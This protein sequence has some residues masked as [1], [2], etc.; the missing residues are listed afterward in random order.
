MLDDAV[1]TIPQA[2]I[3]LVLTRSSLASSSSLTPAGA[4]SG[5]LHGRVPAMASV[6][7]DVDQIFFDYNPI[8]S[9]DT[10][11]GIYLHL[12]PHCAGCVSYCCIVNSQRS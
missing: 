11:S 9:I 2:S 3:L 4:H 10:K 12:L 7:D 5:L 1:F 8:H 6:N